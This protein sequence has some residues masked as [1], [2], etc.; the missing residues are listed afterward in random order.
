VSKIIIE[1]FMARS[2]IHPGGHL[3]DAIAAIG[4]TPTQLARDLQV[5][6]NRITAILQGRRAI[7]ADTALRLARY[8]GTSASF[9]MNLQQLY[10]LRLAEVAITK[11]LDKIP[12]R[13]D[14]D[15]DRIGQ[16]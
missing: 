8:F 2:A 13:E 1:D 12:H 4:T 11:I 15:F 5:P 14:V 6:P 10:D 7:T 9:W 16:R 3:A